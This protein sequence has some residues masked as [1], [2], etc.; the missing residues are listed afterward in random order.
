MIKIFHFTSLLKTLWEKEKLLVTTHHVFYPFGE[1]FCH[2]HQI[3]NCRLHPLLLFWER[4]N[5]SAT[6]CHL[7]NTSETLSTVLAGTIERLK[8]SQR[9]E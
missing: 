1:L 8:G 6:G 2:F 9:S 7:E 4:I 3:Q 5:A